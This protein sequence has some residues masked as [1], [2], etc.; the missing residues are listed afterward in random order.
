M[1]HTK[2]TIFKL[3]ASNSQKL[4]QPHESKH[5]PAKPSTELLSEMQITV[6]KLQKLTKG[7]SFALCSC[8]EHHAKLGRIGATGGE[9]LPAA[10]LEVFGNGA[11]S[12]ESDIVGGSGDRPEFKDCDVGGSRHLNGAVHARSLDGFR[13]RVGLGFGSSHFQ[14]LYCRVL[15]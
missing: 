5:I 2:L 1:Y 12:G 11:V 13:S 15:C 6:N 7:R 10:G 8:S 4:Q 9:D 14:S 3:K